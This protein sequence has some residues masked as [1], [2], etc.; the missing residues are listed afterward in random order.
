LNFVRDTASG[1]S[2]NDAKS[3]LYLAA[4]NL[5][6]LNKE[7]YSEK[8]EIKSGLFFTYFLVTNA[9]VGLLHG[10]DANNPTFKFTLL[11]T[12]ALP[13]AVLF[14]LSLI[15][16]FSFTEACV[17]AISLYYYKDFMYLMGYYFNS[18]EH[19][20]LPHNSAV[21]TN[22]LSSYMQRAIYSAMCESYKNYKEIF[23]HNSFLA[24]MSVSHKQALKIAINRICAA[25][26]YDRYLQLELDY[27]LATSDIH[28][29]RQAV[30][31]VF[32]HAFNGAINYVCSS[33]N[34]LRT[35]L[36]VAYQE[37]YIDKNYAERICYFLVEEIA[38]D[39]RAMNFAPTDNSTQVL[40]RIIQEKLGNHSYMNDQLRPRIEA[41]INRHH[42][43]PWRSIASGIKNV[44]CPL[45]LYHAE[46]YQSAVGDW[47]VFLS[48]F[49]MSI[50]SG[51]VDGLIAPQ[52][53]HTSFLST[54][55]ILGSFYSYYDRNEF[56]AVYISAGCYIAENIA[57][58]FGDS[59]K[60]LINA[61]G[62]LAL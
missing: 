36:N 5:I 41:I 12:V 11:T 29:N 8:P 19:N 44:I 50:H 40:Q 52:F 10:A 42:I 20:H 23:K 17:I 55:V 35:L 13:L 9:K 43:S 27:L 59:Y 15:S 48:C 14:G 33:E 25:F 58:I 32:I 16:I 6:N 46:Q 28:N 49:V 4:L 38:Y 3:L 24:K 54:L 57:Y 2:F 7:Y 22:A 53:R 37:N 45:A 62:E 21:L 61:P 51:Y 26:K 56:D 34:C 30:V 47:A 39:L 18:S 31:N 1:I 60:A